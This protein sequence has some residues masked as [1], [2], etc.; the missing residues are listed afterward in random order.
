[1]DIPIICPLDMSDELEEGAE[2]CDVPE[3]LQEGLIAYVRHGRPTGSFLQAVISGDLFDAC[4]RGDPVSLA[5]LSA[6]VLFL[7][8]HAPA[9]CIGSRDANNAWV[10]KGADARRAARESAAVR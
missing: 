9:T 5:G 1:M 4:R 2:R 8:N 3:H 6:L 7:D 10:K